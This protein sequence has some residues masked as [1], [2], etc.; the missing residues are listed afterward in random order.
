M[1]QFGPNMMPSGASEHANR[2]AS[3]EKRAMQCLQELLEWLARFA[4]A[5]MK[6]RNSDAN[7]PSAIGYA[8]H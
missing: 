3:P 2:F 5:V 1:L 8:A 7:C 6:H 4:D